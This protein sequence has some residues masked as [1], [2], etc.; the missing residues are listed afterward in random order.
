VN[1]NRDDVDHVNLIGL[2]K[3]LTVHKAGQI[4]ASFCVEDGFAKLWMISWLACQI[5]ATSTQ[6]LSRTAVY[7]LRVFI[8][9][10]PLYAVID[11]TA[12]LLLRGSSCAF[13]PGGYC[14]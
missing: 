3:A 4:E 2:L 7:S 6:I 11:S 13:V 1:V 9:R 14:T 10:V 5:I 8:K 12:D